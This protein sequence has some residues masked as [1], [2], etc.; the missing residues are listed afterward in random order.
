LCGVVHDRAIRYEDTG[1]ERDEVYIR[2]RKISSDIL[3]RNA[4]GGGDPEALPGGSTFSL[5]QFTNEMNELLCKD[6]K[7]KILWRKALNGRV[8]FH[9]G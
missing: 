7:R 6:F 4:A 3:R 2:L 1:S 8:L 5:E 9:Q